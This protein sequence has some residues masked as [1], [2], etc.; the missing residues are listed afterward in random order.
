MYFNDL[1]TNF[2]S[3]QDEILPVLLKL[4]DPTKVV[5]DAMVEFYLRH[6]IIEGKEFEA[7]VVRR[8]CLCLLRNLSNLSAGVNATVRDKALRLAFEWKEKMRITNQLEVTGFMD[9][10]LT[11]ELAKEFSGLELL[12][13]SKIVSAEP[14]P[15]K[16][17]RDLGCAGS[18][19]CLCGSGFVVM[20]KCTISANKPG[21]TN[22]AK[23]NILESANM[24]SNCDTALCSNT[25]KAP[26]FGVIFVVVRVMVFIYI[27]G[28]DLVKTLL[29]M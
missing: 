16:L 19:S 3:L 26:I 17:L 22:L 18:I 10:V 20:E 27:W 13:L 8:T 28:A 9:L 7:S 1:S 11:Y 14:R 2:E 5:L 25:M 23:K 29:N 4:S 15:L 24:V 21:P 6:Q 12:N